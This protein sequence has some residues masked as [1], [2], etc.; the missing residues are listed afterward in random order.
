MRLGWRT[1]GRL[2]VVM[3]AA[4]GVASCGRRTEE[5]LIEPYLGVWA[6]DADRR[7]SDFLAILDVNPLSPTAG[8]VLRTIPVGSRGNE[9]Y[10]M[11]PSL[12]DDR[13]LFATG[14]VTSRTFVFDLGNPLVGGLIHVDEPGEGR[15]LRSP[16]AVRSLPGGS[17][18]VAYADPVGFRG[19][20]RETMTAVGGLGEFDAGGRLR[21]E[22]PAREESGRGYINA[23]TDVAVTAAGVVVTTNRGHLL[24]GSPGGDFLP[25][26]T[27]QVWRG[28]KL[29]PRRTVALEAGPRGEENLGPM[30]VQAFHRGPMVYVL[31]HEGG[32][33]YASDSVGEDE[34]A[35]RMIADLGRGTFPSAAALTPDDH[36]MVVT[37]AGTHRVATFDLTDGWAP[38]LASVVRL[39]RDPVDPSKSRPGGPSALALSATG[40]RVAVAD[41]GMQ[42]PAFRRDGDR[43]VHLLVLDPLTGQLRV[44]QNFRDEATGQVGVDFN[45][46]RWP[47]GETGP[48]RPHG[49]LFLAPA[50]PR[51]DG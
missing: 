46:S 35:F 18:A 39:D 13:R 49:L 21:R 30:V 31:T 8:K 38:R 50:P 4:L 9:P 37:L 45:R 2:A 22:H 19:E 34:P 17:V 24:T 43:R 44:D 42:M 32:G 25:G 36:W 33:L 20:A 29:E 3:L 51:E 16:T 12:R 7:E 23:T 6:G 14:L 40:T 26:I 28:R 47:H 11:L 5:P 10:A 15:V 48:A 41:Y 27:V 1:G